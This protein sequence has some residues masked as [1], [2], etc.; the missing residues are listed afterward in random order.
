M[1]GPIDADHAD[2]T[3][4][5]VGSET[6][7]AIRCAAIGQERTTDEIPEEYAVAAE[8]GEA[9]SVVCVRDHPHRSDQLVSL[10]KT[11]PLLGHAGA[12]L[13]DGL[14]EVLDDVVEFTAALQI[15]HQRRPELSPVDQDSGTEHC[16]RGE[17]IK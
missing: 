11:H 12:F 2:Y 5:D 15:A 6:R 10:G 3:V 14:F 16:H 17:F 9:R 1:A 7:R 8:D 4:R 13:E